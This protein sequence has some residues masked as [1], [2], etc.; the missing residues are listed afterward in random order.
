MVV[1][2]GSV[3]SECRTVLHAATVKFDEQNHDPPASQNNLVQIKSYSD[4][5]VTTGP[6]NSASG[7]GAMG[8]SILMN[9]SK[10]W[11]IYVRFNYG[12]RTKNYKGA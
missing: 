1:D 8:G 6:A 2:M 12:R 4:S 9:Y 7:G 11:Q 10:N 3:T 5:G